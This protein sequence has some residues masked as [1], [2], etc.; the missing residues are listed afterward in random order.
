MSASSSAI[1]DCIS[2]V[3]NLRGLGEFAVLH[4]K[5]GRQENQQLLLV[6]RR[7]CVNQG[8]NLCKRHNPITANRSFVLQPIDVGPF[9]FFEI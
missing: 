3:E 2:S 1:Q 5:A 9:T 7:E 6:R 4:T 8:F